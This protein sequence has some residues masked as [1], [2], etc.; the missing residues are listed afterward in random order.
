LN[1]IWSFSHHEYKRRASHQLGLYIV[2]A[3]INLLATIGLVSLLGTIDVVPAIG[4]LAAMLIT[5]SWN[6]IIFK[7]VIFSHKAPIR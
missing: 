1:R 6:F 7:K 2:L 5:S 4:K 3:G